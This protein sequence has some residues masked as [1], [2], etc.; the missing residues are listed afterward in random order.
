MKN[1]WMDGWM[2]DNRD[3]NVNPGNK[4]LDKVSWTLGKELSKEGDWMA[5]SRPEKPEVEEEP[6][7]LE[8]ALNWASKHADSEIFIERNCSTL[9]TEDQIHRIAMIKEYIKKNLK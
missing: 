2:E 5:I 9:K 1:G 6:V 4:K 3:I 8:E 7:T